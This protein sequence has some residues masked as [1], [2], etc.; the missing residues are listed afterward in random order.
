MARNLQTKLPSSDTLRVYD[1]NL[2]SME[3]FANETKAL[4]SGAA[5]QVVETVREAAEDSVSFLMV[6]L[7][8]PTLATLSLF[9]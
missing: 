6:A 4:G 5:V 2:D 3:R 7:V 1:I 8:E 9:R